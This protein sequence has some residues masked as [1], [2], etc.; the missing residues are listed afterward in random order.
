MPNTPLTKDLFSGKIQKM[1]NTMRKKSLTSSSSGGT[2]VPSFATHA[3]CHFMSSSSGNAT[4]SAYKKTDHYAFLFNDMIILAKKTGL[5]SLVNFSFM[6][7]KAKKKL[8]NNTQQDGQ[9]KAEETFEF[10]MQIPLSSDCTVANAPQA[11]V[12]TLKRRIAAIGPAP[13]L[14]YFFITRHREFHSMLPAVHE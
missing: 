9:P 13:D 3:F 12:G 4:I 7:K 11:T 14:V 1:T 10:E 6:A 2:R 5:T 8:L